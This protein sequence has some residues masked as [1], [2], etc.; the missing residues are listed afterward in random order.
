MVNS[1]G[2]RADE[3]HFDKSSR[4]IPDSGPKLAVLLP[5]RRVSSRAKRNGGR[6]GKTRQLLSISSSIMTGL[7]TFWCLSVLARICRPWRPIIVR[8]DGL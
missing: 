7:A 3:Q 5:G 6:P 4:I 1:V 8:S 2:W